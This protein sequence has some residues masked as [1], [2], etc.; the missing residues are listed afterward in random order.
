M[1]NII[2]YSIYIRM[3]RESRSKARLWGKDTL[4]NIVRNQIEIQIYGDRS[5]NMK[6]Q[7]NN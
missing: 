1:N 5:Q 3:I 6:K 7:R 4:L 2:F